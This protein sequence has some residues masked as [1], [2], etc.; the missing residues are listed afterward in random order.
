MRFEDIKL[1]KQLMTALNEQGIKEPTAIQ[2]KAIPK[3]LAG[4]S[5][6][7]IAQT[8]TGKTLAYLLPILRDLKYSEEK[9][10]RVIIL[11]PT[12][13]LAIQVAEESNKL[14]EYLSVKTLAVYGGTNMN[15]QKKAVHAGCDILVGTPGRFYDLVMTGILRLK[16]VKKLVVDECDEMLNLGFRPQLQRI[17]DLLPEKRQNL[18]FSA[19][20]SDDVD[21]IVNTFFGLSE[22][23][24]AAPSGTP[25][26]NIEQT[27]YRAE[28]FNTKYNL[29][30]YIIDANPDMRC[31]IFAQSKRFADILHD[32]LTVDY[33]EQFGVIHSNKSQNFRMRMVQE[34]K[35]DQLKGI[36]ATDLVSRGIDID[37]VSHVINFDLPGEKEQYIHRIGRTGRAEQRG[38]S[39]SFVTSEEESLFTGIQSFMDTE[40]NSLDFPEDVDKSESKIPEEVEP[41]I[42]DAP[43]IINPSH[44]V[45]EGEKFQEKKKENKKENFRPRDKAKRKNFKKKRRKK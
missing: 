19:T 1:P 44:I 41:D 25:L 15:T 13:E 34:F 6:I 22:H 2:E 23:V 43:S 33:P 8:G 7:G 16:L 39:I 36:V 21:E 35:S 20:L 42:H 40:I 4:K 18:L 17:F 24:I 29:L 14:S 31:F 12:R 45:G 28:N 3:I 5:V 37:N 27:A 26:E 38:T 32:R 11:V 9:M 30:R 10:P